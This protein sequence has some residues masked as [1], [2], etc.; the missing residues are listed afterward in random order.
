MATVTVIGQGSKV[1][2][3]VT[4]EG[5]LEINGHVEGDVE[6]DGDVTVGEGGLVGSNVR[7]RRLVVRGAVKGDLVGID[8]VV[9]EAGARV[10]GDLRAPRVA[11]AAGALVRGHVA[12]EAGARSSASRAA[13]RAAAKVEPRRVEAPRAPAARETA[14]DV[15]KA[16]RGA[17]PATVA[18]PAAAPVKAPPP[19]ARKAPAPVVPV[20]KKGAKGALK[21]RAG[22]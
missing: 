6:V 3:R 12:T 18:R 8:A 19:A 22:G 4:G 17:P 7:G 21:K 10:V 2:G 16:A 1:V 20:L 11:I 9:L 5:D 15:N 14:R 13:P